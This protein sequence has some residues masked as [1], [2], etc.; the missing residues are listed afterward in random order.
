[1]TTAIFKQTSKHFQKK[2]GE[3]AKHLKNLYEIASR[4]EKEYITVLC[5][6]SAMAIA[7]PPMVVFPIKGSKAI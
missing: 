1:M 3:P 5:Y 2:Y 7:A 4:N 6:Y